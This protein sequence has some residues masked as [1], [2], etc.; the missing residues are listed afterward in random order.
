ML[1]APCKNQSCSS[2]GKPHPNCRCYGEMAKGG[3]VKSYCEEI[4]PHRRECKLFKSG[5]EVHPLDIPRH[6][7]PIEA[8]SS[9]LAHNGLH[10]L[11]GMSSKSPEEDIESYNHSINKGNKHFDSGFRSIFEGTHIPPRDLEKPKKIIDEWISKGGIAHDLQNELYKQQESENFAKGGEVKP[12]EAQGVLHNHAIAEVYPDHNV[13][14]QETKGRVSNYLNTLKPQPNQ[15]KLAFDAPPDETQQKKTY[16]KALKIAAHPLSVMEDIKKGTLD[17][18]QLD[19]LRNMYPEVSDDMQKRITKKIIEEQLKGKKP[20]YLIRQGLSLFM[21]APLSGELTPQNIMAAQ[22]TFQ[23][24]KDQTQ[25]SGGPAKKT[26]ALAKSDQS[27]LTAD[28]AAAS[29]QQ[30]Q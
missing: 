20:S 26:S 8:V 22:A 10:G 1:N 21:G 27:Y 30:K 7:D 28:Q 24:K 6:A 25:A 18:G 2:Y 29:R 9:Y 4:Q 15:P 23:G 13:M 3:E 12:K 16:H 19:H 5:G 17:P 14:L 11:I